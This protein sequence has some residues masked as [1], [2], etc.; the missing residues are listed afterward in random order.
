MPSSGSQSSRCGALT[1]T[2]ATSR[3]NGVG[4]R[5]A[6][7]EQVAQQPP[8]RE[9]RRRR[10]VLVAGDGQDVRSRAA[11][12]SSSTSRD[13]PIPGSPKRCGTSRRRAAS[14]ASAS[15][16][17][18]SPRP[19]SGHRHVSSSCGA[20]TSPIRRHRTGLALHDERRQR[21]EHERLRPLED[22]S[23]GEHLSGLACGHQPGREVD[24]V[25]LH[26]VGPPER[27][28]EVAG[29][30]VP[31]FTPMRSGS[32]P[33]RSSTSRATRSIRSSSWSALSGHPR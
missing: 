9:V 23:G 27:R 19:M 30:D 32:R 2:R 11:R 7:A 1:G 4:L 26:R 31:T 20:G 18:S 13:L 33:A 25:A 8:E 22:P 28:A 16:P 15:A 6:D 10:L 17:S 24:R 21:A 12:A 14:T 3:S 5:L 29:E